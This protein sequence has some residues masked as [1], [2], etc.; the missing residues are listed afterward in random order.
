MPAGVAV[1]RHGL[2]IPTRMYYVGRGLGRAAAIR[3]AHV[4]DKRAGYGDHR[5]A[6]YNPQTGVVAL[7]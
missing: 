2:R 1:L 6:S 4:K 3:R 5:G 7:T